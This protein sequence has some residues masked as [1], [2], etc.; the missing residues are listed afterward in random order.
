M[1]YRELATL[2]N[3]VTTKISIFSF[4]GE[5]GVGSN[6]K[7]KKGFKSFPFMKWIQSVHGGAWTLFTDSILY[8]VNHYAMYT[9]Y[10]KI[11]CNISVQVWAFFFLFFYVVVDPVESGL[12]NNNTTN[13]NPTITCYL[14]INCLLDTVKRQQKCRRN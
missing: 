13:N 9:T 8:V 7:K 1:N 11:N 10:H 12:Y 14:Y 5:G 6:Q 4:F 3:A 2:Q